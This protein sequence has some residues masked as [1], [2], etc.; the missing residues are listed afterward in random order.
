MMKLRKT[1]MY[2]YLLCAV[3]GLIVPWYYNLQFLLYSGKQFTVYQLFADGMSTSLG[4]S[5]TMDLFIGATP[6]FIWMMY[7]GYRLKMKNM[8]FYF[9]ATYLIA[10]A[11]TCPLFLYMRERKLMELEQEA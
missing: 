2:V 9:I 4:A 5:I 11:F 10:F 6:F 3:A 8:W 7:E 1:L